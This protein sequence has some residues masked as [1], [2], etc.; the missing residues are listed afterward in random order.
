MQGSGIANAPHL[1]AVMYSNHLLDAASS[2]VRLTAYFAPASFS[3]FMKQD[4]LC[5]VL[6]EDRGLVCRHIKRQ[7]PAF[8]LMT[9]PTTC[10]HHSPKPGMQVLQ[11]S[12]P[13]PPPP[14][15]DPR[16]HGRQMPFSS[17]VFCKHVQPDLSQLLPHGLLSMFSHDAVLVGKYFS[18][19]HRVLLLP[20]TYSNM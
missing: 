12:T 10:L 20:Q 1:S 3:P 13:R 14:P 17:Y 19:Q 11:V 6:E 16:G 7:G 2:F 18:R 5:S 8:L 15:P 9:T 4:C